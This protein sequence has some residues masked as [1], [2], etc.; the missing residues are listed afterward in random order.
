MSETITLKQLRDFTKRVA[1]DVEV[2]VSNDSLEFAINDIVLV[3][4]KDGMKLILEVG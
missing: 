4:T 3:K 1:G 2:S